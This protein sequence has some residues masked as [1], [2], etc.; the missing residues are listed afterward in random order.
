LCLYPFDENFRINS[1]K[2]IYL[3]INETGTRVG[4]S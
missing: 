3:F 2:I 1:F 4:R